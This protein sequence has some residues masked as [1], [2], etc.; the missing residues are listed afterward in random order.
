[1][2]EAGADLEH[3]WEQHEL[4]QLQRLARLTLAQKLEWLEEAQRVV[5]ERATGVSPAS[6]PCPKK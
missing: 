2:S 3:C 4:K 5:M 6:G 1:M